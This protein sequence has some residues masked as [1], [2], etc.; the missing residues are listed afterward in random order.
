MPGSFTS[1]LQSRS[2]K[3]FLFT[4]LWRIIDISF[5]LLTFAF[6][7]YNWVDAK[8][9]ADTLST[10][11]VG[12]FPA[13]LP[14]LTELVKNSDKTLLMAYDFPGYGVFSSYD[15]YIAYHAAIM[16]KVGK[17]QELKLIVL[18]GSGRAKIMGDQFKGYDLGVLKRSR[19]FR[20]FL[21]WS[22]YKNNDVPTLASFE[23]ILLEIQKRALHQDFVEKNVP[24]LEL[25]S[26]MPVFLWIED[27]K[28]AMFSIPSSRTPPSEENA[29]ITRDP[30]LIDQ[31][32]RIFR[33]YEKKA[34]STK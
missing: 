4:R 27:N 33:T 23:T 25:D 14:Q 22:G 18:D 3:T 12:S 5:V 26:T 2:I 9:L 15:D 21:E 7:I 10:Q 32:V 29:F 8:E 13:F 20:R 19:P 24:T 17:L 6:A 31:L 11:Y 34:R 30:K 1:A 16:N 28:V